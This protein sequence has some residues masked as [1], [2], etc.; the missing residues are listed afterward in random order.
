M[1]CI[2][3]DIDD[4]LVDTRRRTQGIWRHILGCEV[5][6]EELESMN[7]RQ[8][9]EKYATAE[10]KPRIRELQKEFQD[11]LLCRNETGVELM[12]LDE[13]IFHSAKVVREWSESY[14]IVYLTGRLESIR[15]ETLEELRRFGFPLSDSDLIMF[16]DEDWG[17]AAL[18]EARTR[19]FSSVAEKHDVLRVVD[20]FP[21]YFPTYRNFNVLE[22]IGLLRSKHHTLKDFLDKGAT[23]V[24]ENWK[25]LENDPPSR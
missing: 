1:S 21:G 14:V 20:D 25:Q 23:K 7:A 4:T 8:I 17:K 2:V 15:E 9:F 3:V 24:V 11:T 19:L 18:G 10:Q 5:S 13:P 16:K 22:R 12:A 6:L